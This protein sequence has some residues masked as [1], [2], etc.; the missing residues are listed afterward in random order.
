MLA[1]EA[2]KQ[3]T[4]IPEVPELYDMLTVWEHLRFIGYA[5]GVAN[6]E[7][8]AKQLLERYD[9]WDKKDKWQKNC[10]TPNQ[11]GKQN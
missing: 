2:K 1:E 5:Y 10:L 9:L 4:Y 8:K 3:F 7:M 11:S 6:F